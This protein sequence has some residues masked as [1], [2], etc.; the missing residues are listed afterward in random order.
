M[1]P[2]NVHNPYE[3]LC[4]LNLLCNMPISMKENFNCGLSTLYHLQCEY[5]AEGKPLKKAKKTSK[6]DIDF[7]PPTECI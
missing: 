5:F 4:A 7:F 1:H 3:I 6:T 2:I